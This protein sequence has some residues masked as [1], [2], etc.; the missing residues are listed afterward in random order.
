[1]RETPEDEEVGKAMFEAQVQLKKQRGEDVRDMK[2]TSGS[3][4]VHISSHERFK[5]FATSPGNYTCL[6]V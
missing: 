3:K 2:Y 1:M 6:H 5:D 4:V